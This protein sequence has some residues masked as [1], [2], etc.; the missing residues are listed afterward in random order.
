MK[1][2][3]NNKKKAI[4]FLLSI[5]I[6][7][8]SLL[9]VSILFSLLIKPSE[10]AVN[11]N[12]TPVTYTNAVSSIS[13][14]EQKLNNIKQ[15]KTISGKELGSQ[16]IPFKYKDSV[17]IDVSSQSP[18]VL[19]KPCTSKAYNFAPRQ[20]ITEDEMKAKL[21]EYLKDDITNALKEGDIK[22]EN[23]IEYSF[24]SSC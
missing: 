2:T 11:S 7:V 3:S 19:V 17:V 21:K 12:I 20:V 15:I 16:N 1:R 13:N 10:T 8:I 18:T 9:S 24:D 4:I 5:I 14:D 22:T 6:I 23:N